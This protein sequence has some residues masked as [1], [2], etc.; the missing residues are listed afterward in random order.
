M[1]FE[2][3]AA[4]LAASA[5][6]ARAHKDVLAAEE[7]LAAEACEAHAA[8]ECDWIERELARVAGELDA[9]DP[10]SIARNAALHGEVEDEARARCARPTPRPRPRSLSATRAQPRVGQ[11]RRLAPAC[12]LRRKSSG[13]AVSAERI[14]LPRRRAH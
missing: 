5:A 13:A 9:A 10:R 2:D 6:A 12:A 14:P 3:A 7:L 8:G 4:A 1:G 11:G